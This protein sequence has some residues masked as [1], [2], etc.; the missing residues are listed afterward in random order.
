MILFSLLPPVSL[1]LIRFISYMLIFVPTATPFPSTFMQSLRVIYT[2]TFRIF[3]I[4][5]SNHYSKL[6]QMGAA[7][8]LNTSFKHFLLFVFE[9]DLV[10]ENELEALH[11]IVEEI[12]HRY[13]PPPGRAKRESSREDPPPTFSLAAARTAL[14][15]NSRK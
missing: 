4:I 8:H 13:G 11:D 9:Y 14:S 15:A 2:R 10:K 7:S 12:R 1:L 3:A 5:Y 6:D